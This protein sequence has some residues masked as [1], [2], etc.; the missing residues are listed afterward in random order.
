[1]S[2][3]D[4][5]SEAERLQ[6]L[7]AIDEIIERSDKVA[8]QRRRRGRTDWDV[9]KLWRSYFY[10]RQGYHLGENKTSRRGH[11]QGGA[12]QHRGAACATCRRPLRL[13][14][15]INC[16]DKRFLRESADIFPGLARL[17]LYY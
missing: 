13:I 6:S 11:M 12:V 8:E 7:A 9:P 10:L 1:M 15:E 17:P 4:E 2:D 16:R 3:G 14:W 5:V